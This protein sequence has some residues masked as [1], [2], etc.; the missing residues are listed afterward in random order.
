MIGAIYWGEKKSSLRS[1][2]YISVRD[3]NCLTYHKPPQGQKVKTSR[4]REKQGPS[5]EAHE[6]QDKN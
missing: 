2:T 4:V 1:H 3:R 6:G 5:E